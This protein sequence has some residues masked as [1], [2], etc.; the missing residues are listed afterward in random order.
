MKDFAKD[1]LV[2]GVAGTGAMGRGIAQVMAQAGCEVLLF[3]AQGGAAER[4]REHVAGMLAKLA[5]K[6]RLS[7][8]QVGAMTA[9]MRVVGDVGAFAA[10][11]LVI[12]VIVEN[13]A[14]KKEF[15]A[16][17]EAAVRED[18]ILATNTSS[19]S[20]T[21]I[22]AA[23]K[24]P[25]RV[26]G[27]HFFNPVPL[28]RIVEVIA[29]ART[30][31]AVCAR[32][33]ALARRYGH[34]AVSAADT[35]GF[36]VNHAGRGYGTEALKILQEGVTE[37]HVLDRVMTEAA[38][39]RLGP[40]EL[41]DLT[42]I[43]VSHPVMES[44]YDQYYQEPRYRPSVIGQQRLDAG[45]LGRKTAQGFYGHA[46][47]KQEVFADPVAPAA[48][49]A[50]VWVSRASPAGHAAAIEL[51]GRLGAAIE[52]GAAPSADALIIVTPLGTDATN[53]ALDQGLDATRV[54]ALDTLLPLAKR[55]TLMTTPITQPAVRDAAHGLLAADGVP[56][57][58]IRDSAGFIAQ[59]ILATIVNIGCDIVQ[60]RV[61]SP[62]DLDLAVTLGLSYPKGPLA[63]GDALGPANVLA[64]LSNIHAL[65]G[66]PRY[67]PS[68][69][70]TR[71]ARLGVSLLTPDS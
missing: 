26:A 48:R 34:T 29:G 31:P 1:A 15:F 44:I 60:Q 14:V 25:R 49:P 59:R 56:V 4:A 50:S 51:L 22:A 3:D 39:F 21:S 66:D 10:C 11:D 40:C 2:V 67:R 6:G 61:C 38:G 19:L 32:L 65:T 45:L 17:L 47:G 58:V 7:A 18:C 35:P 41:L 16:R 9:A 54:V 43:D 12:E 68:P 62:A 53:A 27:Y 64:I 20:V 63:F 42:G 5:E 71:R 13:L 30:D 8:Q 46:D 23:C 55:R 52:S 37:F 28:M 70:L 33:T 36:I 69:W 57:A 24:R